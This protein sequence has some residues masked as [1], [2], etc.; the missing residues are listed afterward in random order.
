MASLAKR[1]WSGRTRLNRIRP[2]V[3]RTPRSVSVPDSVS[4]P[5]T[6]TSTGSW[7]SS[8]ALACFTAETSPSSRSLEMRLAESMPRAPSS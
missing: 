3:V 6:T 7:S 2:T 4:H 1:I 8:F 5:V